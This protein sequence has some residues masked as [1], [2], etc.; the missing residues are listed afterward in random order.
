[1]SKPVPGPVSKP[2]VGTLHTVDG[3]TPVQSNMAL[4]ARYGEFFRH[5]IP[6]Q[7]PLYIAT[8]QR[9]SAELCD[10]SR[11]DKRVHRP[12]REIRSFAG[13]GLFTARTQEEN[14]G[15]AHRILMSSFAPM[16]LRDM[17]DG[18]A[19]IAEQLMLKWERLGPEAE[20]DVAHDFTRLTLDTIALCS[21]SYRFN[22]FYSQRMHPF[23]DAMVRALQESGDRTRRL[24]LQN[25]LMLLHQR[26]FAHD[27]RTMHEV[28]D[29]LIAHRRSHPLPD[30]RRD[31]LDD[32]LRAS[33]PKT[34]ERLSDENVRYQMV[35]FLIA[36]HETTSGL[37]SFALYELLRNPETTAR[38]RAVV[39]EVLDGRF[40]EYEDLPRLGFLDQILRETLRLWPT[41][42]AFAVYPYEPTTIGGT[43][44]GA[45]DGYAVRPEDTILVLVPGLHRDPAVWEQPDRFDPDRF[46]FE[47][48]REIPEGAWKPFGNGQRS[49]IGRGFALQEA[50]LVLALLLQRFEFDFA[51]AGYELRVKET[52]TLKPDGFLARFRPRTDGPAP[53]AR[54]VGEAAGR[55]AAE[56]APQSP[57]AERHGTPLR[58][59][60]GSNAGTAEAFA[61]R[62][63]AEGRRRGY[64]PS[65]APLDEGVDALPREGAVLVVTSSYEGQ[66][67]D[68]ARAFVS[69]LSELPDG[70][71]TGVRTAVFGCGN[72][73]WAR[74][75]QRIPSLVDEGFARAGTERVLERGAANVRGD[76]FGDFEAWSERLW[77]A[78]AERLGVV[79]AGMPAEAAGLRV[80]TADP[81]RR[82]LLREAELEFGTVLRNVE[83]ADASRPEAGSKRHLEILLPEGCGYRTG[84]YLAVLPSNPA[85]TVE[86]ALARFRLAHDA[87]LRISGDAR[88]LP[89]DEPVFAG[90]VFASY[91][92][93]SL[94]AGRRQLERLAEACPCPPER[95]QLLRLAEPGVYEAEVLGRRL[96]VLDLLECF[97]SVQLP[98]E[99]FLDM[100]V[101]LSPRRYSIS[102]SPLWSED[103]VTL[104]VAH[105]HGPAFS[106]R[107]EYEGAA[108]TLLARARPGSRVP[109]SVRPGAAGFRPPQD[110]R[111]PVIMACAGTGIA[112]FRGFLQDRAL[113]AQAEG[114]APGPALLFFGCRG[115]QL[116]DLYR[117]ELD[118]WEADGVVEV[119]RAYSRA[120]EDG[121]HGPVRYVQERMWADRERIVRLVRDGATLY[122]CGDGSRMAPA[123]RETCA[124]IYAEAEGASLDQA[125]EWLE[126]QEREH[127]RYVSDVYA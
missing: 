36:G 107:G 114:S 105:L 38:A 70:A 78:L 73:D 34:G 32:M 90:E 94:P 52:L 98:L 4:A 45:E 53:R 88:G 80:E 81:G 111:A 115:P 2:V 25:E 86:R 99:A 103:R 97:P 75:Y 9:L 13:D 74:S 50:Q 33:D 39:D 72:T 77:P 122:V 96:S 120:P 14:W 58:I 126:V 43:A 118:A 95:A 116:D 5:D 68:N 69:W 18:M 22:S 46:G 47:R 85:A 12:L 65:L 76:F 102:S 82:S 59:L 3:R 28:A 112:P 100:L 62:L 30:G 55:P 61:G 56:G 11:F 63:A 10:Q 16:A 24:P 29:E 1:M 19:D 23:V 27:V 67:P 41:A 6:G 113:R 79:G 83:L 44:P 51:D 17:Y 31:I 40:P 26:R 49:C 93:L 20:I 57:A 35:T 123:V 42:P 71:L 87:R 84:D 37:L 104:T 60:F 89:V 121:P 21:F 48:A 117:E 101:P 119:R 7:P 66:P 106:G 110:L 108:S 127:G 109:V 15:R 91:V 8:S 125:Q 124:R 64:Q 92:E 54:G